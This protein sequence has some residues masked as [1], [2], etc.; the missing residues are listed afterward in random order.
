M[1]KIHIYSAKITEH[2][3]AS[4]RGK[5][6]KQVYTGEI[7]RGERLFESSAHWYETYQEAKSSLCAF[8][9]LQVKRY[10]KEYEHAY[11]SLE[12]AKKL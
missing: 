9:D 7:R 3:L 4:W 8:Y 2:P 1:F 5:N 11:Q 6:K 12:N 10:K